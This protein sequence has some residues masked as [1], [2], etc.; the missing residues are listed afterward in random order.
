A[1]QAPYDLWLTPATAAPAPPLGAFATGGLALM[2]AFLQ[3]TTLINITGQPAV[4]IPLYWNAAGIPLGAHFVA[5]YG[6]E[7]MLF[8]LAAQL[9]A[10]RPWA[11]RAPHQ[12]ERFS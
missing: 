10:A 7:G 2:G 12:A 6:D 3:F 8:R 11:A 4:S 5:P 1:F 9:E